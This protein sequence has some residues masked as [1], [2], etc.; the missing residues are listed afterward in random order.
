MMALDSAIKNKYTGAI[1]AI[2]RKNPNVGIGIRGGPTLFGQ[3]AANHLLNLYGEP[4]AFT[5]LS[6]EDPLGTEPQHSGR[7]DKLFGKYLDQFSSDVASLL[8][9]LKNRNSA[10]AKFLKEKFGFSGTRV[11]TAL[12]SAPLK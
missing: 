3:D 6:N 12:C 10:C 5:I 7:R 11:A 9:Q 2:L 8:S 1:E 4:E